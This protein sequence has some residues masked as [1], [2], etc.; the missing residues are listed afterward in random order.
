MDQSRWESQG[1]EVP[2]GTHERW[3]KGPSSL[4]CEG[5]EDEVRKSLEN[6]EDFAGS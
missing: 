6:F 4:A 2:E 1:L 3:E 5:I